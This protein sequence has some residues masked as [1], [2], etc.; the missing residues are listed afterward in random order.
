MALGLGLGYFFPGISKITNMLSAGTINITLAIGLILIM[1][2]PLAKVD[3]SLL[4]F[5]RFLHNLFDPVMFF[6]SY[7]LTLKAT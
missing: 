2:P 6:N 5:A 1:Y 4:L 7:A 3:Y